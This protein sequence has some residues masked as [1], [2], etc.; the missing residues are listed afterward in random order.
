M[1]CHFIGVQGHS[2]F[3]EAL[4]LKFSEGPP[5]PPLLS[6]ELD[7][8][9]TSAHATA[10]LFHF[11]SF[12]WYDCCPVNAGGVQQIQCNFFWKDS[13][14]MLLCLA[15]FSML[16]DGKRPQGLWVQM[17]RLLRR[18]CCGGVRQHHLGVKKT[19]SIMST[20]PHLLQL[21]FQFSHVFIFQLGLNRAVANFI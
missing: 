3:S 5:L 11:A 13:S 8:N 7:R 4:A 15:A 2:V 1:C 14:P 20:I 18:I 21:H 9:A 19:A 10:T 16:M 12:P 17:H 6:G